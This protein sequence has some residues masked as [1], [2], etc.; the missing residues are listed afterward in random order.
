MREELSAT[1]IAALD[2]I[3][4]QDG[5]VFLTGS[6]QSLGKFCGS[7][8]DAAHAL[9]AFQDDGTH[10]TFRQFSLPGGKVIHR[11]ISNVVVGIDG[12]NNLRIVGHLNG[13]TCSSVE[14]LFGREHAG[15]SVRK[16]SEFQRI[17]VCLGSAI[18]Q[19]QLIVVIAADT[20]QTLCQLHLQV[21][22]H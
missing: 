11:Q 22:L 4:N 19:K 16:R 12:R 5:A 20:A 3:A 17:L 9:D 7:H 15:T 8:L 1:A 13:K 10:I 18:D 6:S 2:F 14:S 21:V